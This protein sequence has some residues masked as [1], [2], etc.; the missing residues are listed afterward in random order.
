MNKF[1]KKFPKMP[2]FKQKG[3]YRYEVEIENEIIINYESKI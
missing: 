1:I 2:S 3:F